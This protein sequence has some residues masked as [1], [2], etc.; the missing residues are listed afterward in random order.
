MEQLFIVVWRYG[1]TPWRSALGG[2][3]KERRLA[4]NLI[5][6]QKAAGETCDFAIVEGPITNPRQMA[7]Q[8]ALMP[9]F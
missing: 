3:F 5:E 9:T 7:E 6:C 2:V 8:E 4:E 1:K